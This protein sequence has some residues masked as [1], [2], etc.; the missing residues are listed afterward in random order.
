MG[1]N[2]ACELWFRSANQLGV[3]VD[4]WG[5]GLLI[6][7]RTPPSDV[8]PRGAAMA[9]LSTYGLDETA[10]E[11]LNARWTAWWAERYPSDS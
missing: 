4:A 1:E 6:V 11:D 2:V 7:A 5:E 8:K 9:V 3:T 10:F